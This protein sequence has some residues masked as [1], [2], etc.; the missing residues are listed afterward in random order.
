MSSVT[1]LSEYKGHKILGLVE[2]SDAK[3]PTRF[4]GG[5]RKWA[6]VLEHIP[7]IAA[8][9][10]EQQRAAAATQSV[11]ALPALPAVASAAPARPKLPPI[12]LGVPPLVTPYKLKTV[13]VPQ[14]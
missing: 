7:E 11:A 9:V 12:K 4:S 8:F 3:Y 5:V 10:A 13:G 6:M 14:C 2:Q 1:E